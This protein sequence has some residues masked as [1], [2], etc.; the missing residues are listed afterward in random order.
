MR[1]T[2]RQFAKELWL[3]HVCY[4]F[5]KLKSIVPGGRRYLT[6]ATVSEGDSV[7]CWSCNTKVEISGAGILETG[8]IIFVMHSLRKA[9]TTIKNTQW[10]DSDSPS[11]SSQELLITFISFKHKPNYI[12]T[13]LNNFN[14]YSEQIFLIQF[15]IAHLV[16]EFPDFVYTEHLLL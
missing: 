13:K 9:D 1:L 16:Q 2:R 5:W 4:C 10:G 12:D 15:K 8:S 14:I 11:I 7:C 3:K 6:F